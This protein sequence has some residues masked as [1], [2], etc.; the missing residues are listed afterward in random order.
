MFYQKVPNQ[1]L[2]LYILHYVSSPLF[3]KFLPVYLQTIVMHTEVWETL[4]CILIIHIQ[5]H[6]IFFPT[7]PIT[8]YQFMIKY[9]QL[10]KD[11]ESFHE[12]FQKFYK[13]HQPHS[14]AFLQQ[15]ILPACR[16]CATSVYNNSQY[17]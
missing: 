3:E 4:F 10:A 13:Y 17:L 15:N 12:R 2:Q 16:H 11:Q 7:D 1:T 6:L 14:I 9:D 8:Q 5:E